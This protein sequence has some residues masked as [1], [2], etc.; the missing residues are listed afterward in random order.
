MPMDRQRDEDLRLVEAILFAAS[1]P[2][3]EGAIV[4]RLGDDADV[5]GLL[6]ELAERYAG[7]GVNVV[8]V[9]DKWAM[10]TAPD[11]APRLKFEIQV[12]RK[13]SRAAVETLAII[14]YHQPVTRAEVEEIR[15]VALSKGTLEGLMEQGWIKPGRRREVPG[16]PGTWMTTEQFLNHFGLERLEDLPGIGELRAAGLLDARPVNTPLSARE[17]AD[18][19]ADQDDE[20]DSDAAEIETANGSDTDEGDTSTERVDHLVEGAI[21]RK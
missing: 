1:E 3:T 10:R 13:L 12:A 15:G 21:E 9:G 20:T 5:V 19:D 8:K 2:V 6:N 16:R 7:R 14:A 11:L 4:K 17:R 18:G